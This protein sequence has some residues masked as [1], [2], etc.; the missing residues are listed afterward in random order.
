[1]LS[2]QCIR[3]CTQELTGPMQDCANWSF[4][5]QA[6]STM[7]N[8]MIATQV[9]EVRN[10]AWWKG[11]R[12]SDWN[13]VGRVR[14]VGRRMCMTMH[15]MDGTLPSLMKD[16]WQVTLPIYTTI[17]SKL[18]QHLHPFLSSLPHHSQTANVSLQS[19]PP[20]HY[21]Q[22]D[23][24]LYP[25][26]VNVKMVIGFRWLW[27]TCQSS[28]PITFSALPASATCSTSYHHA[29]PTHS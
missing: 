1:M 17:Q 2:Y 27:C 5:S 26:S 8:M 20:H 15:L 11:W 16:C 12:N 9:I 22:Y 25:S 3:I 23:I 28:K 7:Y 4:M 19:V 13:G 18:Q 21:H 10:Q 24:K 14:W 6:I 29:V